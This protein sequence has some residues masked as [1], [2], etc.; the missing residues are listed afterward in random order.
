MKTFLIHCTLA[1]VFLPDG[2][3]QT[4]D[5]VSHV[6]VL[7]GTVEDVSSLDAWKNSFITPGMS[8]REKALAVW[9][10]VVKF[11]HQDLPP[12]EFLQSGG[13]VL[14]PIKMFNV[15]GYSYCSVASA[16]VQALARHAGLQARGWTLNQHV[17]PEIF[18]DGAWHL[19]DASLINYFPKPDGTLAEV[20]EIVVSIKDWYAAHPGLKGNDAQ[21]RKYMVGG[22]W[23]TGPAVLAASP[24]YDTNGWLPSA[25]H[26]WY[27]TMQEYDGSTLFAFEA[28]YSLGYEVNIQLRRGERLTRNWSNKGL[29]VNLDKGGPPGCLKGKAGQ[30]D[31]RYTPQFGDLAPGRIGN[32]TLEYTAPLAAAHF[33]DALLSG[34]NLASQSEDAKSP[35]LHVKDAAHPGEFV[36]RM[37]SSY[38]YLTGEIELKAVVGNSGKIVVSFSDNNGLDWKPLAEFTASGAQRVDLKPLVL[39]RYDYR[40]KFALHGVGTGLDSLRIAHDIQHSQR[41]LPA[42]VQGNNTISFSAGP[43]EGTVTIEGSTELA[44][45]K[46]Q[47]VFTD[48]H[49]ES[50]GLAKDKILLTG[51]TGEITFPVET[52]GEITRLRIGTFYRARDARDGWDVQVSFDGGQT[53][54]TVEHLQGPTVF[55]GKYVVVS[56][57]PAGAKKAL[58]RYVGTQRNTTMI[59]NF[60]IDA[61]YREPH[62]GFQPVK[63]TYLWEENGQAKSD[64]H[65]ARQP[66]E[67]YTIQ[68]AAKPVMKSIALELAE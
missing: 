56:D 46:R 23:K 40:L 49:P 21:L 11:Q 28:G 59:G 22:G 60:R 10:S 66:A 3:S 39:R 58:V 53:F 67:K 36:L 25:A 45:K 19:L 26:G 31:L 13:D 50:K 5:V 24:F 6:K 1:A 16:E 17:V 27:S 38:V 2:R 43:S 29:H 34:E 18:F 52:P 54:K 62:G 48:F 8:D 35:A 9:Q 44:N 61:D 12:G 37:P 33:R 15:Y 64:I 57:V 42:L 51:A 63:V 4:A 20:Q 14:D 68:C 41:P 30:G 47:L 55:F 32:G 65:I 7:S